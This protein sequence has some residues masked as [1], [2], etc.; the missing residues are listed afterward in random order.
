MRVCLDLEFLYSFEF[1]HP[2][3]CE[4]T[5]LQTHPIT[6]ASTGLYHLLR[7]VT[8]ALSEGETLQ[9]GVELLL[10]CELVE[11]SDRIRAR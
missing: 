2:R 8:L 4:M 11:V 7:N 5:V 10:R 3:Y 6:V 1:G 9:T